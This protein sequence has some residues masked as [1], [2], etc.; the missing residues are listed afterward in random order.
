MQMR[1]IVQILSPGM[2]DG[3]ETERG[4]QMAPVAGDGEQGLGGGAKKQVVELLLVMEHQLGDGFRNR[5]D[6]VKILDRQQFAL[7]AFQ[8]PGPGQGLALGTVAVA[9]G[10]VADA[11][12]GTVAA[13]FDVAA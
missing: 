8:P 4:S 5:E 6:D 7:P 10:V 12:E 9:A 1:M 11:G 3:E 13:L 2:Q